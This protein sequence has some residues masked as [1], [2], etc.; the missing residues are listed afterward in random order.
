MLQGQH[1]IPNVVEIVELLL[2]WGADETLLSYDKTPLSWLLDFNSTEAKSVKRVRR[3]LENAPADC[4][5]RRRGFMVLCRA[6]PDRVRLNLAP[7]AADSGA[8]SGAHGAVTATMAPGPRT[9]RRRRLGVPAA[10]GGGGGGAS[11]SGTDS[12]QAEG[13]KKIELGSGGGWNSAVAAWVMG[14]GEEAIFRNIVM[15]L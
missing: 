1:D 5:W 4:A 9:S 11:R 2:R 14:T 12:Q 6:L 13:G 10:S 8:D 3:L 15:Y 7:A